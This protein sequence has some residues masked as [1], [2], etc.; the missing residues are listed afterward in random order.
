MSYRDI[1]RAQLRLDEGERFK[2][3]KD[4]VGKWSIGVGRNLDDVGLRP[5]EVALMLDNDI[6]VAEH[7]ARVLFPSFETLSENRKAVLVNMAFNLGQERLSH[8][9]HF[10][11]AVEAGN[12]REASEEMLES[13]WAGQVGVRA[14]RLAE[15]ML[16]G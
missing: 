10:R 6:T 8:F 3:Y 12:W 9:T 16:A 5:D 13:K 4:S 15:Q 14:K 1:V 7:T 11:D 2:L